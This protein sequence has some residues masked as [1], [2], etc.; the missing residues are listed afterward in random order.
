MSERF[1]LLLLGISCLIISAPKTLANNDNALT[2]LNFIQVSIEQGH[3]NQAMNLLE[4]VEVGKN[5]PY[6][7]YYRAI[8]ANLQLRQ[9]DY[10][11]AISTYSDLHAKKFG[12]K[13][14]KLS[15]LNNYIQALLGRAKIYAALGED[16]RER[17]A[18]LKNREQADKAKA[19]SLGKEAMNLIQSNV[20]SPITQIRTQL[21]WIRLNPNE[22]HD[23]LI[24]GKIDSLPASEKQVDF[25]L[26]L[27]SATLNPLSQLQKALAVAQEL[28]N[29][30]ILSWTW[31]ALGEYYEQIGD[32]EAALLASHKAAWAA[33]EALDWQHLARW[34]WLSAR[35]YQNKGA[36]SK[37][38][39]SYRQAIHSV[40][41]LRQELAGGRVGQ[42]LYFETIEPLLRDYLGFLLTQPN[43]SSSRLAESIEVIRLIQLSE[44]DNYFGSICQVEK[45]IKSS[46]PEETATIYTILL[47]EQAF[48]ILEVGTDHY[49]LFKLPVSGKVM[50]EKAQDWRQD[51]TN[52]FFGNPRT[53]ATKIYDWI[54]RPLAKELEAQDISRIVFVQD[55]LLRNLPVAALYDSRENSF[56]IEKYAISYSLGLGDKLVT[57][58]PGNPLIVGSSQPSQ[59]FPNPLPGVIQEIEQ[60]QALLGGRVLRD[61]ALTVNSLQ[62]EL[63]KREY[64]LLHF[65]GHSRFA[66]LADEVSIQVGTKILNLRQFETLI[67][68]RKADIRH[69]TLSACE[70][71]SGS[72]FATLGISGISLRAGIESVMGTLWSADDLSSAKLILNF[73]RHWQ[74]SQL[75]DKS[76][77][78]VQI[79]QIKQGFSPAIWANFILI[80]S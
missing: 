54:I 70:T 77:Q 30:L 74:N 63:D 46:A 39:Q 6:Y 60:V 79:E 15:L 8:I 17:R 3:F 38:I 21:N 13:V 18:E 22:S 45:S 37:A 47:P 69:L 80:R 50:E 5:S 25:L 32:L 11:P 53:E 49:Q 52:R 19:R 9:G 26:T 78:K 7:P 40:R 61:K 42:S 31:G 23:T 59:A 67:R 62:T 20:G 34:Q 76:L 66:G 71:A 57:V 65:S 10:N 12:S 27:A 35:I 2:R 43:P 33:Q 73:Y 72:R 75:A 24:E 48:A 64:D 58:A 1:F 36:R 56:L 68:S 14:N 29:P 4:E 41:E 55:G 28:D 16:N 51:L 44:L